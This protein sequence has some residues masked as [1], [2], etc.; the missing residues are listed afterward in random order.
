V[1]DLHFGLALAGILSGVMTTRGSI[2][3]TQTE[4]SPRDL[5]RE[6]RPPAQVGV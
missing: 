1:G 2:P 5:T 4:R 3:A 6:A